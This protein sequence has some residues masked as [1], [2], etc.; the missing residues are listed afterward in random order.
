MEAGVELGVNYE[1][2]IILPHESQQVLLKP[3]NPTSFPGDL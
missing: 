3:A 1:Q 2:P